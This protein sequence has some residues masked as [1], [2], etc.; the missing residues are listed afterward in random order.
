MNPVDLAVI[1]IV[2]LSALFG[3]TRGFI[4]EVFSAASWIGAIALTWG[5]AAWALRMARESLAPLA[6]SMPAASNEIAGP[7]IVMVASLCLFLAIGHGLAARLSGGVPGAFSRF[8]GVIF[9]VAR[10]A[11]LVGYAYLQIGAA[12][13]AEAQPQALRDART[14]PLIEQAAGWVRRLNLPDLRG[15][16]GQPG[17][18]APAPLP[19][20]PPGPPKPQ[21]GLPCQPSKSRS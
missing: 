8:L 15:Q 20:S 19:G 13:P 9:G 11:F 18:G 17:P 3:L 14:L 2:V 1:L 10:G 5:S 12:V 21:T 16:P 6:S 4:H 7:V